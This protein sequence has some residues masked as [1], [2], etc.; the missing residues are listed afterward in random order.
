MTILE[1]IASKEKNAFIKEPEFKQLYVRNA[2]RL[3]GGSYIKTIDIARI[4]AKKPGKGAFRR[5]VKTLRE[6][7]PDLV[8]YVEC[9]HSERF[10]E[11]LIRMGFLSHGDGTCFYLRVFEVHNHGSGI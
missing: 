8:V 7:H 9:V 6:K 2:K 5:L 3:I 10:A 1:F 4:E 11:G